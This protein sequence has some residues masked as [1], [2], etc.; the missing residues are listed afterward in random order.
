MKYIYSIIA[1]LL[2][3]GQAWGAAFTSKATG[4]WSATGQTTWNEVGVPGDGDTVTI[5]SG[6][7]V[8]VDVNTTVGHSPAASDG[9]MAIDVANGGTLN[10]A[11]G[12]T[13]TCRG[14]LRLANS[15]TANTM[16]LAA[17]AGIEFDASA[18]A[19]PSTAAYVLRHGTTYGVD[20]TIIANG[21]S[22]SRC[23]IR[24][25][26]GGANASIAAATNQNGLMQCA[27]TDFTRLGTS[28]V[29]AMQ[30]KLKVANVCYLRNCTFMAC[31]L[32]LAGVTPGA[33]AALDI[34]NCVWS[35][36]VSTQSL[37]LN[38]SAAL[39]TGTRLIKGN[40][41]DK[42]VYGSQ[43][44]DCTITNNYFGGNV[45]ASTDVTNIPAAWSN[46]FIIGTGAEKAAP[47][48][49]TT[50]TYFFADS[51]SGNPHYVAM[52]IKDSATYDGYIFDSIDPS[53]T[54][55][56]DCILPSMTSFVSGKTLTVQNCIVLPNPLGGTSGTLLTLYGN[57]YLA[58]TANHNTVYMGGEGIAIAETYAGTAGLLASCQSN[59]F[60][61]A[62]VINGSLGG[63]RKIYNYQGSGTQTAVDDLVT[64]ADYNCGHNYATDEIA[65]KNSIDAYRAKGYFAYDAPDP[66]PFASAPGAHDVDVDPGFVDSTRNL[67][68]FDTAATGLNNASGT[69][70]SGDSVSYTVDNVVS[71]AD[72]TVWGGA[73]VNYRCRAAHTSASKATSTTGQPG[74]CAS[75]NTNWELQS[76]FRLREDVTRI[77]TLIAW[78]RAGFAP[79]NSDL[80]NAG[81]D[82]VT[83]G[84][85]EGV[86]SNVLKAHHGMMAM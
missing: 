53:T 75:W 21:T 30:M 29:N 86:F 7:T 20:S 51:T 32:V 44:L 56:G 52:N 60:W 37:N 58:V 39:T 50:D 66:D 23:F 1:V 85:V 13:L 64:L 83:I 25:N 72:A 70:W 18:A 84:A 46:N 61:N 76:S 35:G 9:T 14:D 15:S 45:Q 81:H 11:A 19:T 33:A 22:G 41:F 43:F 68:T 36:T 74:F 2:L 57:E 59:I 48:G 73:T 28:S 40:V 3:A 79:T 12:V 71:A 10:I 17:G 38:Y 26:A 24:S 4:N 31:G 69:A 8:T 62:A 47:A 27:Y 55:A 5:G 80:Q 77:A 34:Q 54:G 78:V 67:A 82:S 16:T 42:L 63:G 6:H 65:G 49:T